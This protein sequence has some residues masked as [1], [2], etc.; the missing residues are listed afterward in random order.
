MAPYPLTPKA[1]ALA[2]LLHQLSRCGFADL[3]NM[4]RPEL[5]VSDR[6]LADALGLQP[7][8]VYR[9]LKELESFGAVV[10][11][12]PRL[13]HGGRERTIELL[14]ESWVWLAVPA[15]GRASR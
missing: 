9:A 14:P 2:V 3:Q 12:R 11:S 4:N 13:W 7:D 6:D 1:D 8:S 15:C 5:S 10:F